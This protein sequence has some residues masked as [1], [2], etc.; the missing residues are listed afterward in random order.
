MPLKLNQFFFFI[1]FTAAASLL[2]LFNTFQVSALPPLQDVTP[3]SVVSHSPTA[4]ATD[5]PLDS[6]I[7]I[8]LSENIDLE[9]LI[10]NL[11]TDPVI[12]F[13]SDWNEN[14]FTFTIDPS[15]DF[16]CETQYTV[17]IAAGVEDLSGNLMG[18]YSWSFTTAACVYAV[19][20]D[21]IGNPELINTVPYSNSQDTD[22]ATESASDPDFTCTGGQ[23]F[24]TVW[25]EYTP[26]VSGRHTIDTFGSD[27]D[28]ILAVW[29]GTEGSLSSVACNNDAQGS[30]QSQI[31]KVELTQGIT[32]FI[33]IASFDETAGSLTL[34][35]DLSPVVV[36]DE[37]DNAIQISGSSY[38]NVQEILYATAA[39]DDPLFPCTGEANFNTVWFKYQPPVDGQ[40]SVSTLGSDY[41]TVLGVWQGTQ[42]N[43]TNIGC[44][45]DYQSGVRQSQIDN[46][47]VFSSQTYYIEVAAYRETPGTLTFSFA[48]EG[49]NTQFIPL[50]AGWNMISAYIDPLNPALETVFST[51]ADDVVL[52]KNGLGGLFWPDLDINEIGDWNSQ[53]GYQVYMNTDR[54][55]EITGTM[56][57]PKMPYNLPAGW[58]LI[59]YPMAEAT[60]V[61]E[62]LCSVQSELTLFK[63]GKGKMYWPDYGVNNI[64]DLQP[65]MGYQIH[66]R[67]AG[68]LVYLL[69]TEAC[70]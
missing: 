63:D 59:S 55:F 17:N 36:N 34:N 60:A 30:D 11:S 15:F 25:Y 42:G 62:T 61:D 19:A 16:T 9:S 52:V 69:P 12:T 10:F 24:N 26:S 56:V 28:T 53:N 48:T 38:G 31:P 8:T 64:N 54:E 43:L 29:Q 35:V 66:L 18:A 23:R 70:S 46:L 58:S 2:I 40:I 4:D 20:N 50:I 21:I 67:N 22:E 1:L 6:N 13:T 49:I 44:N 33:E 5:V 45:D 41:D 27:Y 37:F 51:I 7:S 57:D 39:V 47:N 3:P 68:S 65:G 14:T 32:Y